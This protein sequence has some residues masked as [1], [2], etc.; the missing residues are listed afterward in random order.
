MP[1]TFLPRGGDRRF[2]NIKKNVDECLREFA[3][4]M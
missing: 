2:L 3:K 1:T 4:P